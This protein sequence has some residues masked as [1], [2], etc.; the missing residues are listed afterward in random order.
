MVNTVE[1]ILANSEIPK[2]ELEILVILD[3]YEPDFKL[4]EDPRVRYIRQENRGMRGAINRAV[5]EAKGEYI[6]RFDE[7]IMVCS[8]FD[9]ILLENIEDN[10]IV[11]ATRYCLDPIK[12]EVMDL[13][14]VEYSK[15]I[16]AGEHERRKFAGVHWKGKNEEWKDLMIGE[17]M[18]MQGSFW[19]MKKSWWD[20]V[21]VELQS[22]GY[23]THYQDSIEMTFKTWQAGGKL[24]LN[25]N[26]WFAHKHRSFKRTHGY[27]GD[28]ANKSFAY[29]LSVWE[30]YYRKIIRP[31]FGL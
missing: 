20:K 19:L 15:L 13:P 2:N 31:R 30:P 12:W 7:H 9:R 8:G 29:A 10:W 27:G 11:T 22:E 14:P 18:A 26:A 28:L 16:V 24:M 23:G 21:I 3:G 1:S 6:A 4:V 5:K 25:K 17:T